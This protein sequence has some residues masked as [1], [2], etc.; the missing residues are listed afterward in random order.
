MTDNKRPNRTNYPSWTDLLALVGVFIAATL[1]GGVVMALLEKTG[2]ASHGFGLFI[3][4]LIQFG[5]TILYVLMHRHKRGG[6]GGLRFSLSRTNPAIVLWG[7]IL[8][9][10]VS[11]VIEPLLELFPSGQLEQL[12]KMVG[13]GG[14]AM[15]LAVIVAPI[16][17]EMLFRGIIQESL[18]LKYGPL[19]GVLIAATVFGV[20]HIIPAQAINAFFIGLILGYV[21]LQTRSLIPVI[22]IHAINNAI[23]YVAIMLGGEQM[24]STHG[25]IGND[26]VYRI[27]YIASIVI[28]AIG[29]IGIVVSI[30]RAIREELVADE[31]K[32][33]EQANIQEVKTDS[34]GNTTATDP[35]NH[36]ASATGNLPTDTAF[37]NTQP[38]NPKEKPEKSE[39]RTHTK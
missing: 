16:M 34:S 30:R 5:L 26:T 19:A 21:Y 28:T 13:S 25:M 18:T 39:S 1:I 37:N 10:S 3:S 2:S 20:V 24:I 27:V 4:Y 36:N 22:M 31:Q 6:K 15:L 14:W 8:T 7:V 29:I 32:T 23:A 38:N 12:N 9:F 33:I 17:E 35:Y 11:I